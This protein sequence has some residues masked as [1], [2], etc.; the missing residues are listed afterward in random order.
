MLINLLQFSRDL[1]ELIVIALNAELLGE[2][3]VNS[4]GKWSSNLCRLIWIFGFNVLNIFA[5]FHKNSLD[6][7]IHRPE[8]IV[9]D[10]L[11]RAWNE[12]NNKIEIN[13]LIVMNMNFVERSKYARE[14]ENAHIIR[15]LSFHESGYVMAIE[16]LA[17]VFVHRPDVSLIFYANSH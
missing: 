15:Q 9:V 16:N 2:Q 8:Y 3:P 13:K 11:F 1:H 17:R 10:I 7:Y 4:I 6:T 5:S 12:I 14:W